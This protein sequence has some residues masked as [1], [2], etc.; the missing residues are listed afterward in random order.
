MW[1]V[2][3]NDGNINQKISFKFAEISPKSNENF[4]LFKFKT[5]VGTS[6][7]FGIIFANLI[8]YFD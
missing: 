7:D 5:V 6:S 4:I 2:N 3:R 8:M 1:L